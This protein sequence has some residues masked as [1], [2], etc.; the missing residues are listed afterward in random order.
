MPFHH[1]SYRT[2]HCYHPLP[3]PLPPNHYLWSMPALSSH[4][5][6]GYIRSISINSM[7]ATTA[8][9]IFDVKTMYYISLSCDN[10]SAPLF[11]TSKF[12][13]NQ[14]ID[15][16]IRDALRQILKLRNI[17][18]VSHGFTPSTGLVSPFSLTIM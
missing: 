1:N 2:I 13:N 4:H 17:S 11:A 12:P 5:V 7:F 6:S 3:H 8:G 18:P 15:T 16:H 14:V 10:L 9:G